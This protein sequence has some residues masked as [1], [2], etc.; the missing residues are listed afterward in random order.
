M[1]SEKELI[2]YSVCIAVVILFAIAFIAI[3]A[4]YFK[5]KQKLYVKQIEDPR[6]QKDVDKDL[7]YLEK[8]YGDA[9]S[10]AKGVSKRKKREKRASKVSS[11]FLIAIYVLLLVVVGFA[12]TEQQSGGQMFFGDTAMLVVRTSSMA[13]INTVN[14]ADLASH[15]LSDES[16]RL[17]QYTFITIK[18]VNSAD[19]LVPYK[20]YA[21]KMASS[22]EGKTVTIVHRLIEVET[23]NGEK[24][25]TFRGD[26]NPSSLSGEIMIS[27][28]SIVGEWTGFQ[29]LFLGMF[30][31]Y[32]QSAI[33]IITLLT[34]FLLLVIYSVLYGRMTQEYEIRYEALLQK[35][36]GY[37]GDGNEIV[38]EKK[39]ETPITEPT[40]ALAMASAIPEAAKPVNEA[41]LAIP[42]YRPMPKRNFLLVSTKKTSGIYLEQNGRKF[43]MSV[44]SKEE[45]G[46]TYAYCGQLN[47]GEFRIINKTG[48]NVIKAKG[49]KAWVIVKKDEASSFFVTE[50]KAS[51]EKENG[52]IV[53]FLSDKSR[54]H[55]NK[56]GKVF[57]SLKLDSVR[58]KADY[59]D[60]KASILSANK[61]LILSRRQSNEA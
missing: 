52:D 13:E 48:D 39:E 17:P 41:P 3:S 10:I 46:T 20:V 19:D 57:F 30:T 23:K 8:R 44:L 26:A 53:Y 45:D 34:A 2:V 25:F 50:Q 11:G 35:K 4:L 5:S 18:K 22:E 60:D 29:N 51:L 6:V 1:P 12:I 14:K 56:V 37:D 9:E 61:D 32:L 31:V 16:N 33:G 42:Y 28:D 36:V 27:Y 55:S 7:V 54:I 21:F 47:N 38:E 58:A 24:A 43:P 40:P 59:N 15:D 49:Y